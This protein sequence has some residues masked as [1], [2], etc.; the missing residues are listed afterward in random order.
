MSQF[1]KIQYLNP[2]GLVGNSEEK[3]KAIFSDLIQ[4]YLDKGYGKIDFSTDNNIFD[5]DPLLLYHKRLHEYYSNQPKEILLNDP[6]SNYLENINQMII[7]KENTNST[8]K[9][10]ED[11]TD[12]LNQVNSKENIAEIKKEI[13]NTLKHNKGVR[14]Y[15]ESKELRSTMKNNNSS[16]NKF[17]L[18]LKNTKDN[19]KENTNMNTSKKINYIII[20]YFS[21]ISLIFI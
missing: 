20:F 14:E 9:E 16:M 1:K 17:D 4:Q 10:E 15:F 18:G 7:K 5:Q 11:Y 6:N 21:L 3:M 2:K 19:L 8:H 12:L 13:D